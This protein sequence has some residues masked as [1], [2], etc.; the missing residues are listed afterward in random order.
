[1]EEA[2]PML[3]FIGGRRPEAGDRARG[4]HGVNGAIRRFRTRLR[5]QRG[6]R[7][8]DERGF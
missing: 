7:A 3:L 6:E 5:G 8:R 4:R 2:L 1:M